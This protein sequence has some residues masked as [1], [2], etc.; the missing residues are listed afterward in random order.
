MEGV[1]LAVPVAGAL[2]VVELAGA[3]AVMSVELGVL[4]ALEAGAAGALLLE[5]GAEAEAE[6]VS[7]DEVIAEPELAVEG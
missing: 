4:E 7:V 1:E 2:P 3:E 5:A 6:L